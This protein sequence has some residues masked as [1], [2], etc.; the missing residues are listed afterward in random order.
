[1]AVRAKYQ[2]SS[3]GR[4]IPHHNWLGEFAARQMVRKD[5]VCVRMC[6]D[7]LHHCADHVQRHPK[8]S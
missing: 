2:S 4:N 7:H 6:E 1:M 8:C 3:V 5:G